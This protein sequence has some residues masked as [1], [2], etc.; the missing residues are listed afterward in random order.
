MSRASVQD[1]SEASSCEGEGGYQRWD[2]RQPYS[3]RE[4]MAWLQ[5][6]EEPKLDPTTHFNDFHALV[7]LSFPESIAHD[8]LREL[9]RRFQRCT[10][11]KRRRKATWGAAAWD[12]EECQT[13]EVS[14]ID[15]CSRGAG[16]G[17]AWQRGAAHWLERG[18]YV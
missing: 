6:V 3:L 13:V 15:I 12:T 1:E 8:D 17:G 5:V 10:R 4:L 2:L 14:I 11:Q 9:E 7:L 18:W 16:R